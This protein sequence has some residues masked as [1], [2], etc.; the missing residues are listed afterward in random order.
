MYKIVTS[1]PSKKP[2]YLLG[3]IHNH[4]VNKLFLLLMD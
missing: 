4:Q 3:F 2:N 1:H